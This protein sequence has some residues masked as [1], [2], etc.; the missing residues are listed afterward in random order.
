MDTEWDGRWMNF[1][2]LAVLRGID[3]QSARRL[4]NRKGWRRQRDNQG[5]VR[6]LV[7]PDA[8]S[9]R[10][11]DAASAVTPAVTPAAVS[12]DIAA[13]LSRAITALEAAAAAADQRA[14]AADARANAADARA[15][16]ERAR[17]DALR[18]RLTDAEGE[19]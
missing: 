12:A 2:Q 14:A 13:D 1:D 10:E 4:V 9:P 3:R 8:H 11:R 18:D 15:D 6:V 7:P 17:A 5:V 19:L 16:Q